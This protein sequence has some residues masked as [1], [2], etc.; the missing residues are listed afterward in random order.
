MSDER[1]VALKRLLLVGL[2]LVPLTDLAAQEGPSKKTALQV[3]MTLDTWPEQWDEFIEKIHSAFGGTRGGQLYGT[4]VSMGTDS[5]RVKPVD[6]NLPL[7]V[8]LDAVAKLEVKV[9]FIGQW[10]E[11][12]LPLTGLSA[13][14]H[15]AYSRW[16]NSHRPVR[17]QTSPDNSWRVGSIKALYNDTLVLSRTRPGRFLAKEEKVEIPLDTIIKLEVHTET[18]S[19]RAWAGAAAGLLGGLTFAAVG[20]SRSCRDSEAI[21]DFA[22]TGDGSTRDP[23]CGISY[24]Y[25]IPAGTLLGAILGGGVTSTEHWEPIPLPLEVGLSSHGGARVALRFDFGK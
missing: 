5:L 12:H 2:L 15:V 24:L 20:I 18:S 14:E 4:V 7:S 17:I 21:V 9:K 16:Y 25:L 6:H 23:L 13:L 11:V 10:Q 8:C 3:R 22:G 1:I 19:G